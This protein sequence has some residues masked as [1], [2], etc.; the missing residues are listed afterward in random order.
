MGLMVGGY[1]IYLL[2][3]LVLLVV[4]SMGRVWTNTLLPQGLNGHWY[5]EVARDP[6]FLS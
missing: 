5:L 2:L 1:L 4:G 6:S 3:P